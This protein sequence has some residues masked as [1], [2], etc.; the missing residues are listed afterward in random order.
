MP[1]STPCT[2]HAVTEIETLIHGGSGLGRAPDGRAVFVPYTVPGDQVR[3][4][5]RR[6]YKRYIKADLVEV[7]RPAEARVAAPC[8]YFGICGGCDWH[9]LSYADQC[10]WK[11]QLLRE[12]LIHTLG[13]GADQVLDTF[14]PAPVHMGYRC[15][16]QL[17]CAE[18]DGIFHLGFY[19]PV[20]REVVDIECCPVLHPRLSALL[21]PLR[22]LLQRSRYAS[23]VS[24]IEV[25]VD[26][27]GHA[28]L[29]FHYYSK[30][31]AAFAEWL[32]QCTS[33]WD[34]AIQV[35]R[36][37]PGRSAAEPICVRGKRELTFSPGDPQLQLK[38]GPQDFCQVNL[39]QNRALVAQVL[40]LAGVDAHTTVY[41]LY[42]GVGNFALP[43]A[44]RAGLVVG[45]EAN[46]GAIKRA[47]QNART[48]NLRN[49]RFFPA[50][51]AHFL[52]RHGTGQPEPDVVVLDPPRAGAKQ[53]VTQLGTTKTK[54][55]VYISCD[56]HTLLRDIRLLAQSGFELR[57]MRGVDMFPYTHHCEVVALLTRI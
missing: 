24:Q 51:V 38:Y 34:A 13:E 7:L 43:L 11:Q 41:D 21:K 44:L 1:H 25:G 32:A 39:A 16:A 47:T 22:E 18:M 3:Y 40:E 10:E 37:A 12:S 42:C 14:L 15:R 48:H 28:R 35:L 5:I 53:V 4:R 20:T 36:V 2:T 8:P 27:A 49:T 9:M 52:T 55:V 29:L 17:K 6:E 33:E 46:A 57:Y 26:D 54:R 45:V 50:D 23:G 19:R 30:N 31:F 56:Q